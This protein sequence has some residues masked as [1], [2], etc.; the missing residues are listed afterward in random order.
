[1]NDSL[2]PV[3]PLSP[4]APYIG[5]KKQ[6]SGL[7]IERIEAIPHDTYAEAFLGM[8]GVFLRRRRAPRAEV[9]NDW[10][11][12]VS[13]F[14]RVL[15]RHYVAFL[16][17]MKFDLTVRSEFD[18]LVAVDPET[19]TDLERAARFL[20]L[21]RVAYGGKVT[22]RTFGVSAG[23]PGS[24]NVIR[25]GPLLEAVH[26]RLAGVVIERLICSNFIERYDTPAT[27]FYLD[28]PYW[29]SEDDYG[30]GMFPKG[31]FG[32]LAR[33]LAGIKG[34]FILSLNDVE[35]VR[36]IFAGFHFEAVELTYGISGATAGQT[37]AKE[38]LISNVDLAAAGRLL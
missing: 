36:N 10:S 5:G 7:I 32:R 24:F 20:Y 22:G 6:L 14:F 23:E 21:Q 30:A 16:D 34:K 31:E 15:Q 25:L 37:P 8:G 13:N 2:R 9:V 19:L 3:R 38:V 1:M 12:D 18:R 29:N 11:R 27:L 17:M 35:A 28:P 33:Q 4:L 26:E